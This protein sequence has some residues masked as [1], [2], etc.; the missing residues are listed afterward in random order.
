MSDLAARLKSRG[1]ALEA[2][3]G[4]SGHGSGAVGALKAIPS[5]VFSPVAPSTTAGSAP[6]LGA[7]PA[8]GSGSRPDRTRAARSAAAGEGPVRLALTAAERQ[9]LFTPLMEQGTRALKQEKKLQAQAQDG[10]L[11]NVQTTLRK[12]VQDCLA[13]EDKRDRLLEKGMLKCRVQAKWSEG[14]HQKLKDY[15]GSFG[16]RLAADCEKENATKHPAWLPRNERWLVGFDARAIEAFLSQNPMALEPPSSQ[17]RTFV[18]EYVAAKSPLTGDALAEALQGRF[19]PLRPA[20]LER[21]RHIA[22]LL[23]RGS[24]RKGGPG[25]QAVGEDQLARIEAPEDVAWAGATL[26]PM[27]LRPDGGEPLVRAPASIAA[28]LLEGLK[29]VADM[30]DLVALLRDTQIGKVVAGYRHHPNAEVAKAAKDLVASW[31][32]ACKER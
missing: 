27:G 13:K 25:A 22:G 9:T 23:R 3:L 5:A 26:A 18:D 20:T 4:P 24:K 2:S 32:A 6:A 8:A 11:S 31:R 16:A 19:G 7:T 21:A 10:L 29:A 12:W 1:L 28:P 15:A 14:L 30:Q 17:V